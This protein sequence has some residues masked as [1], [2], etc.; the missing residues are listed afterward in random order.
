M[1]KLQKRKWLPVFF[2]FSA[3]DFKTANKSIGKHVAIQVSKQ[4]GKYIYRETCLLFRCLAKVIETLQRK[5]RMSNSER[6]KNLNYLHNFYKHAFNNCI[7][8]PA[9]PR[10]VLH[11]SLFQ[12]SV[13]SLCMVKGLMGFVS[14]CV[15]IGVDFGGRGATRARA[16]NN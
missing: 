5:S 14:V 7:Y 11:C 15:Y 10:L 6:T 2:Y 1:C 13:A 8:K 16:P 9:K 3:F 4:V 12:D